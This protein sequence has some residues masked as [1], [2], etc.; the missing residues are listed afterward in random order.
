MAC[1][2]RGQLRNER[3]ARQERAARAEAGTAAQGAAA[4]LDNGRLGG[5]AQAREA[6][7]RARGFAPP[8][9]ASQCVG[10]AR[11]RRHGGTALDTAEG[12]TKGEPAGEVEGP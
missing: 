8:T 12:E 7:M 11:E 5:S 1:K 10:G 2:G 4:T 9:M 6:W 3:A